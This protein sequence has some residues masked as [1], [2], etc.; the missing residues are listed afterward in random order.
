MALLPGWAEFNDAD[1]IIR[2]RMVGAS[3]TFSGTFSADN[4]E[5]VQELNIRNGAAS[6]YYGFTFAGGSQDISFSLPAQP[7]SNIADLIVPCSIVFNGASSSVNGYGVL[8][9]YKNGALIGEE[10]VYYP[11]YRPQNSKQGVSYI[12]EYFAMTQVLRYIDLGVSSSAATTYRV[13]LSNGYGNI[14]NQAGTVSVSI[15]GTI[16]VGV[17][18]R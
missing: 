13:V 3:G 8:R 9:L 1:A 18:K 10:R 15:I 12:N 14:N 5:A 6:A 7:Y 16:V 17:R 2:G 4:V 11:A